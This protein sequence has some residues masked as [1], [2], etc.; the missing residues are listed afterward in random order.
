MKIAQ[1]SRQSRIP[2]LVLLL[3]ALWPCVTFAQ[4]ATLSYVEYQGQRIQLSRAYADFDEYKNDVKNLSVKQAGQ[5]EALMQK[6]RFGPSFA[7]AQAL[8]N[9]LAEL[10]FPG[11]GMFYANQLG[12]HIDTM[13]ELAYVE[14]PMKDRNRYV[15]LEKTPTGGF[16]VVVDFIAGATPEITR[17][18]RG[19][20]GKLVFTDSTGTK[21]VP[22]KDQVPK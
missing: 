1:L 17:V 2:L 11:Y 20:D 21:I 15:V 18:H 13:L 19:S 6:T 5:V 7:N 10:Q 4:S 12:A 16:R 9:A 8:D 14:I 3:G 22:K